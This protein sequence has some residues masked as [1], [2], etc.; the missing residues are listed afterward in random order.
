MTA[1]LHL[2]RPYTEW[3]VEEYTR[4]AAA[5]YVAQLRRQ[6]GDGMEFGT[7]TSRRPKRVMEL[8]GGSV[9]FC[10]GGVTLFRLPFL[11]VQPIRGESAF[12]V[13]MRPELYYV[14]S[15][16]VGMVRG[17]RHLEAGAAPPDL[18]AVDRAAPPPGRPCRVQAELGK[19]GL[20]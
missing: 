14:A 10:K 8:T 17:W 6:N 3:R 16:R 5:S 11:R 9:Y 7:L 4:D 15:I 13:L 2:L 1:P 19:L 12:W 20:A 18:D